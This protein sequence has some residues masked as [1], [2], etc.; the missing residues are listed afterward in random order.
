MWVTNQ[1]CLN[2]WSQHLWTLM[3]RFAGAW[4]S[5]DGVFEDRFFES[6]L[7]MSGVFL[8]LVLRTMC[9]HCALAVSHFSIRLEVIFCTAS[10][11]IVQSAR[12]ALHVLFN[13]M[14]SSVLCVSH[15]TILPHACTP[16]QNLIPSQ[17]PVQNQQDDHR[18]GGRDHM[19]LVGGALGK[20][21]GGPRKRARRISAGRRRRVDELRE[22]NQT[23]KPG[24]RAHG[25][26]FE[27]RRGVAPIEPPPQGLAAKIPSSSSWRGLH[28]P[29]P[30]GGGG[31]VSSRP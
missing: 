16:S 20:S 17:C 12:L 8:L 15:S 31:T 10:L 5:S 9:F 14:P 29:P 19:C 18:A 22:W 21:R 7:K 3:L 11:L 13:H 26:F 4:F 25:P 24:P 27:G 30:G 23:W 2:M 28:H 1:C 6:V